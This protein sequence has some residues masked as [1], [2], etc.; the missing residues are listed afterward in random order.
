MGEGVEPVRARGH[1]G[2]E[3][4]AEEEEGDAGVEPGFGVRLA[5]GGGAGQGAHAEEVRGGGGGGG[6]AP[7]VPVRRGGG[8]GF[9]VDAVGVEAGRWGGFGAGD[10]GVGVG[11]V[12]GGFEGGVAAGVGCDVDFGGDGAFEGVFVEG[13]EEALEL[14]AVV[15]HF[16]ESHQVDDPGEEECDPGSRGD[17]W[18]MCGLGTVGFTTRCRRGLPRGESPI[19]GTP[20]TRA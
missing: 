13:V 6:V 20:N 8:A 18:C 10:G 17:Q 3:Q 12:T 4:R 9:D 19:S 14:V 11:G 2:E 1:P 15:P 5:E 16:A 7:V